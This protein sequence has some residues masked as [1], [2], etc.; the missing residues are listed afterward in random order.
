MVKKF[1]KQV[2]DII[3][4]TEKRLIALSRQSTQ[5]VID[6]TQ[7][8][9]AKGGKMR[10]DT[11]FLRAS[12]QLSLTGLPTGPVRPETD[13]PDNYKWKK[14]TVV[15]TLSKLQLGMSVFFGWTADYAKYRETYDGFL[16]SAIQNW[17]TI[18]DDVVRRIK[19]RIK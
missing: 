18:V 8:P 17:P 19:A 10:V 3:I 4:T 9:V 13:G 6:Q 5:E 16:A 11:G 1:S 12:G 15:T 2:D 7:T 14:T